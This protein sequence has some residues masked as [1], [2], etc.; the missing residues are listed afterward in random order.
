MKEEKPKSTPVFRPMR[1]EDRSTV[2]GMM[3]AL[4]RALQLPDGYLTDAKIDATMKQLQVQPMH[5]S[6]EVFELDGRVVGYALLFKFWYNEFGGMVLNI[7]ELFVEP[8]FRSKGIAARYLSLLQ[9]REK[10]DYVALS[11]EVLPKNERAYSLY[12]RAGFN[13]KETV[14]LYKIL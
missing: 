6:L 10:R 4:Y 13:E 8:D 9:E 14:T 11:L 12:K 2:A 7:D 5:L 1:A 3:K